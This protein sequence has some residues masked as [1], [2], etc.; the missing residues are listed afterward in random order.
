MAFA[1][2][3][4]LALR[5]FSIFS[6]LRAVLSSFYRVVNYYDHMTDKWKSQETAGGC[7]RQYLKCRVIVHVPWLCQIPNFS[8]M[9]V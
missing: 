4:L 2:Y 5:C 8:T 6:I 9:M 1:C 3:M 7:A